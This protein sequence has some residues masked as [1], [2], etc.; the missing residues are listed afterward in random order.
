MIRE[1]LTE[2]CAAFC[3]SNKTGDQDHN[4]KKELGKVTLPLHLKL[5]RTGEQI[6]V[7]ASADGQNWG[8]PRL[9]DSTAVRSCRRQFVTGAPATLASVIQATPQQ[10]T[11]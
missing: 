1:S 5:V 11:V 6:Q 4:Q 2:K 10:L 7:F 8:E 9:T 3:W